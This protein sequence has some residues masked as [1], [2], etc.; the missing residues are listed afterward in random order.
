MR[1]QLSEETHAGGEPGPGRFHLT[2]VQPFHGNDYI[3]GAGQGALPTGD[4]GRNIGIFEGKIC[5]VLVKVVNSPNFELP[6]CIPAMSSVFVSLHP[7][8][9]I[10]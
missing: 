2:A 9:S 6:A 10:C 8:K 1:K 5:W 4:G 7:T 3:D